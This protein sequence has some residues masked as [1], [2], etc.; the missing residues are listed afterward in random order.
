MR[1]GYCQSYRQNVLNS[2]FSYGSNSGLFISWMGEVSYSKRLD[3][4]CWLFRRWTGMFQFFSEVLQ[5]LQGF[6][7]T[8]DLCWGKQTI[9]KMGLSSELV[10]SDHVNIADM[11]CCMYQCVQFPLMF[12]TITHKLVLSTVVY[13]LWLS[14]FYTS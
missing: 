9:A 12:D 2:I 14:F 1:P 13:Y 7:V 4:L 3:G 5:M 6:T 10:K 11:V 8:L